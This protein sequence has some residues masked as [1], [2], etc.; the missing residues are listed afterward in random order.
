LGMSSYVFDKRQQSRITRVPAQGRW[1]FVHTCT[2]PDSSAQKPRPR[3]LV[4]VEFG[5]SRKS[6]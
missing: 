1:R 6:T 3:A 5:L 4:P 2:Q